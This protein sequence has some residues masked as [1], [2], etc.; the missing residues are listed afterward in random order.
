MILNLREN[1]STRIR[2]RIWIRDFILGRIWIRNSDLDPRF[3]SEWK[4]KILDI[5]ES[6][7]LRKS[8]SAVA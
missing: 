5:K 1:Q 8:F 3:D 2:I 6:I 7:F 4:V